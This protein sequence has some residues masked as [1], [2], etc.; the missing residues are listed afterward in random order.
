[1]VPPAAVHCLFSPSGK[2]SC[3]ERQRGVGPVRRTPDRWGCPH[4]NHAMQERHLLPWRCPSGSVHSSL[5]LGAVSALFA[6][7]DS[8]Q[9][10]AIKVL[11]RAHQRLI[12]TRRRQLDSLRSVLREFYPAA[13]EAFGTALESSD[14]LGVLARLRRRRRVAGFLA[15]P[16]PLL[17]DAGV[18]S[19][20]LMREQPRSRRRYEARPWRPPPSSPAP[21]EL[22]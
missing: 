15:A 3:A 19:E 21:S 18:G 7:G 16:S 22:Q 8:E 14:A 4:Y 13:L 17:F 5:S 10:E 9:A 20:R 11:A 12:W 6:T 2:T 1:V